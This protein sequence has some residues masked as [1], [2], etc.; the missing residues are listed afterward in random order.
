MR[1]TSACL[2]ISLTGLFAA[3]MPAYAGDLSNGAPGGIRD[4]G[5]G[6]VPVPMPIAYQ[7]N[8]KW[9]LRGDIGTAFKS[10]G[11]VTTTGFPLE[12]TQ[13]GAWHELSILSFGF[14][15]YITPSFRTEF[16]LDYRPDRVIEQGTQTSSIVKTTKAVGSISKL[17]WTDPNGVSYSSGANQYVNNRYNGTLNEDITYQNSTFLMSGFYDFNHGGKIRPYVGGGIGLAMHQIE[18]RGT[19]VYEC[20]DSTT[21]TVPFLGIIPVQ[22]SPVQPACDTSVTGGLLQTYTST[23]RNKAIGWGLA[24][25]ASAGL[26]VDVAPRVH[27]DSGY[28]MLWESGRLSVASANGLTAVRLNDQFNHEI[29]TGLRWD[30]W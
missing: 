4:Y 11:S 6:G 13:P 18:Q 10:S 16:T 23:T 2:A 25:Q 19:Q 29:R 22:T 12:I 15:K 8:F 3:H 7:E 14:G 26:T 24:A 21:S 17:T 5:S 20:V 28:R 1:L 9:Y 30:L 27:L